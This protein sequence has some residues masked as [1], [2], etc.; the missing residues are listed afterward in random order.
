MDVA[1][2]LHAAPALLET[3]AVSA[4]PGN[5]G[6]G[7]DTPVDSI[8]VMAPEIS[9]LRSEV[10]RGTLYISGQMRARSRTYV[11]FY[12][13]A[14]LGGWSLQVF[15]DT[16][17]NHTA[18]WRGYDY[19]V[20]GVEWNRSANTF[21]TRRITL[22]PETPGGWG[23]QSG[24]ATF[25]QRF[26]NFEIAIPI[27][28]VGSVDRGVGYCVETYA[29]VNCA[30]CDGGLTQEWADDYFAALADRRDHDPIVIV[31]PRAMGSSALLTPLPRH[32]AAAD[33]RLASNGPN[34]R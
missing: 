12:G 31:V 21:V 19:I 30:A 24:I 2:P 4:P 16:D 11:P 3:A 18:Y 32:G 33:L 15:L 1:G 20:R 28:A 17:P 10:R 7:A 22:D 8:H 13:P 27:S 34:G 23:P 6:F 9:H 25:A 26:R 14:T 29:T 5:S